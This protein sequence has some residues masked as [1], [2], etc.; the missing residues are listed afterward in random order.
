M[1]ITTKKMTTTMDPRTADPVELIEDSMRRGRTLPGGSRQSCFY[2][3]LKSVCEDTVAQRLS[4]LRKVRD[5]GF[6]ITPDGAIRYLDT[7]HGTLLAQGTVKMVTQTVRWIYRLH[8]ARSTR[9]RMG[10]GPH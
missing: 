3:M 2:T 10:H 9:R 8:T 5:A 6:P 4:R 1:Q 7:T